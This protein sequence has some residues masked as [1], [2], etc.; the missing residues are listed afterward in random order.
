MAYVSDS[1]EEPTKVVIIDDHTLFAG[2]LRLLLESA[3]EGRI[4]IVGTAARAT[5]AE[6]IVR[7]T[8][9]DLAIVDI[10][11]PPPG[12][13]EAIRVIKRRHPEIQVLALSGVDSA[14]IALA[15][16][17]A[18]ANGFVPK[19]SEPDV[20]L[21]PMEAII[22]GWGIVPRPLL[23]YLVRRATRTGSAALSRLNEE[24][25]SLWKLVA[26]GAETPAIAAHLYVSERTAKRLV[27]SLLKKI[28]A[29]NRV[30]AA[31][32]AGRSGLF[33]GD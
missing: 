22:S 12:G 32:L 3:T 28:G 21:F 23:D 20:V 27:A 16:L 24:E 2:G 6:E 26:S 15:A 7:R 10:A 1:G 33:D 13:L 14:E 29:S 4:K 25:R 30:E 19:S 11:M 31:T 18:G 9:P 5:D 17:A 8:R